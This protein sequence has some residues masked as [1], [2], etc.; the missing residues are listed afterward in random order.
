MEVCLSRVTPTTSTQQHRVKDISQIREEASHVSIENSMI[1]S[2]M[3]EIV[4]IVELVVVP[5]SP[6][7]P[8]V[9]GAPEDPTMFDNYSTH[10]ASLFWQ[11]RVFLFILCIW[12]FICVISYL[13]I[14]LTLFLFSFT[15]A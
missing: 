10:T 5:Q 4:P 11:Q 14:V 12:L 8:V 2:V 15:G 7:T 1:D 13:R 6:A 3:S 9:A